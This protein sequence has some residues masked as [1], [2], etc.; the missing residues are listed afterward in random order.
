MQFSFDDYSEIPN[1]A[2]LM[3]LQEIDVSR[4]NISFIDR[5][6]FD[7]LGRLVTLHPDWN[8]TFVLDGESLSRL[9][10]LS[11]I[12]S[13]LNLLTYLHQDIFK[14]NVNLN[15]VFLE[16]YLLKFEI[17]VLELSGRVK[18][19]SLRNN[20]LERLPFVNK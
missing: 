12:D 15:V 7:E 10:S 8:R 17:D 18:F 20:I 11:L 16:S 13:A 1:D 19:L 5:H 6:T 2:V 14:D 3:R 9:S 4:N